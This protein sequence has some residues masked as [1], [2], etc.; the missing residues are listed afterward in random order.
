MNIKSIRELAQKYTAE[1]LEACIEDEIGLMKNACYLGD[2]PEETVD[3]LSKASYIRQMMDRENLPL[4][5]ALRK[6]AQTIRGLNL[7]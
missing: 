6:L 3:S 5:E 7:K 2:S 4:N 1:E